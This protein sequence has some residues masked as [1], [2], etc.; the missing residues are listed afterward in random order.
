MHRDYA[1]AYLIL[2]LVALVIYM[3]PSYIYKGHNKFVFVLI[4]IFAGWTGVVWVTLL[5]ISLL[6]KKE[7]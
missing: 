1:G 5:I 6:S 4:N 3:I 2:G 7:E